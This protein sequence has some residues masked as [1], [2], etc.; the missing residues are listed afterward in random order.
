[1]ALTLKHLESLTN[2]NSQ[3]FKE[4]E[5]EGEAKKWK[6]AKFLLHLPNTLTC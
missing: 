3:A 1:M 2:T 5:I 4:A 6:K